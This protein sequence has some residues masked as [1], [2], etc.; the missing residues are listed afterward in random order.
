M[1]CI[2]P[3]L[4]LAQILVNFDD[5]GPSDADDFIPMIKTATELTNL[6]GCF[7]QT[8]SDV[9]TLAKG[10]DGDAPPAGVLV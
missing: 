4:A 9:A 3:A 8:P 7:A 1:G 10:P 2:P 5:P 6:T